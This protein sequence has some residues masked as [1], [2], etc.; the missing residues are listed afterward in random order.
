MATTVQLRIIP[1]G[2]IK[3]L[4]PFI[5]QLMPTTLRSAFLK[6]SHVLSITSFFLQEA[7]YNDVRPIVTHVCLLVQ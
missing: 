2:L 6:F 4:R 5:S 7:R 3:V 1:Q